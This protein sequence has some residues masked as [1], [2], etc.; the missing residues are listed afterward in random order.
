MTTKSR[1]P[2]LSKSS[3]MAGLQCPKLLWHKVNE[4][5]IFAEPDAAKQAILEQ[6]KEVGELAKRLFPMGLEVGAGVIEKQKVDELSRAV[7]AERRPLFEAGFISGRAYARADVLVPVGRK[8]W[9]LIEVKSSTKVK[10]EHLPDVALQRHVYERAGLDIRRCSVMHL[11][12]E[13]VRRGDIAP[14]KLFA[15]AEV[16]EEVEQASGDVSGNLR[17]MARVIDQPRPPKVKIGPHC[18]APRDCPLQ[19]LCWKAM[20]KHN[21]FT[22]TRVGNQAFEWYHG[23]VRRLQDLPRDEI[24]NGN[25]GIQMAAIR[26]GQPHVDPD[27]VRDFIAQLANPLYFLDFET[28]NPAIPLW[29]ATRPYQQ[30]PFQFSLHIV[31]V[32]GGKPVHHAYLADGTADPRPEI[33][34]RLKNLLGKHGSIVS[35]NSSFESRALRESTEAHP[36]FAAWWKRIEPRIVD[37]LVP[38]RNFHYYHPDQLGSA[39]LKS[40]LPALTGKSYADMEIADGASASQ[41]YMRVTFGNVPE[42]ERRRVRAALE[43]YCALDTEGMVEIVRK[44][45]DLAAPAATSPRPAGERSRRSRG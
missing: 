10:D 21:V 16:T 6:G 9:D 24:G 33:L 44:L 43:E 30:V 13:Y 25:Q 1:P 27:A 32:P 40:V 15:R 37:L 14:R 45:G 3:Y 18:S 4:P 11:D 29:D 28:I 36:A 38:F 22:L 8:Q 12:R 35:Y 41:E 7:L 17:E 20:P 23:G 39:S 5:E 31:D 42:H 2:I 26:S 19:D 34:S